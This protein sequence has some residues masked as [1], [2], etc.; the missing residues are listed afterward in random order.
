MENNNTAL[1]KHHT[2]WN[3]SSQ[4]I[5]NYCSGLDRTRELFEFV[6]TDPRHNG[7]QLPLQQSLP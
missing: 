1:Y 4:T 3:I 7:R 5:D 6:H 2:I